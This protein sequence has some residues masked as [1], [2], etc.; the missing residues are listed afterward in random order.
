MEIL[1]E[2]LKT[3]QPWRLPNFE[4]PV[5]PVVDVDPATALGEARKRGLEEGRRQGYEVGLE[6]A[7]Q[8]VQQMT[9]VWDAMAQPYKALDQVV[10]SELIELATVISKQVLRRELSVDSSIIAQ[11]VKEA[12][13]VLSNLETDLVI[14]VN[15]ADHAHIQEL[16][17]Q[18]PT[19]RRW[20][21]SEDNNMLPGG[22][23]IKSAVS[24]VDA[25]VEKQLDAMAGQLL[26]ASEEL[27]DSQPPS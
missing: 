4:A 26:A 25:S 3:A 20:K 19:H 21:I 18:T 5:R 13:G 1:S 9:S 7:R 14:F 16:L 10:A 17:D 22:C 12:M 23:R 24:Y 27:L 8:L 15:P 2:V 6:E 11:V